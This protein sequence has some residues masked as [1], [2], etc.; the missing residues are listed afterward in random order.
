MGKVTIFAE[1][2]E[3]AMNDT[4]FRLTRARLPLSAAL[5]A[6]ACLVTAMRPALAVD[7]PVAKRANV[8]FI[9][10]DDQRFDTIHALGN[11]DIE[12]THLDKLVERG[13]VF[14]NAYC[15]GAMEAAV[16]T[17]S[18]TMLMTGKSLFRIPNPTSDHYAG[19]TLG[20]AFRAAGYATLHVGK[21]GNSFRA[22]NEAFERVVYCHG[23][24]KQPGEQIDQPR[25][26]ADAAIDF[27]RNRDDTR[28]FFIYLAPQYPHDPR[29]APPEFM[30]KYDPA[31]LPLAKNFMPRHPFDNGELEVR[32]E[33]L[34]PV[35][36]TPDVMR[37]HLADYYACITCLDHH[38][39]RIFAAL[40]ETS[41]ADDTLIVF[42]SDQGLAVGGRHGLMGKQNLYEEFK[43]PLILAGPRIEHGRSDALVYLY[44]LFPTCCDLAG[45]PTPT[46]IDGI[47][48]RPVMEGS[49]PRI[50]E[51]LFG[52][53]KDCQ[54][55]VR[56]E[57]W[58]LI[59]YPQ[60]SRFQLFDLV[61]DPWEIADLAPKPEHAEKLT[62]LKR[63]LAEQQDRFNDELP[64]RPN[65]VETESR[66]QKAKK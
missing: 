1:A 54:R 59:W 65:R 7:A 29:I 40:E 16:C 51:W 18:R 38:L 37:R 30:R 49:K 39:G 64:L 63:R 14:T 25:L 47:T 42:T 57:R 22:G 11:L 23:D 12:T 20:G 19:P 4:N 17:P 26:I 6:V 35:P 13:F 2:A 5:V 60:I 56:D 61:H 31:R 46:G 21:K 66:S 10:A 28:P 52:A 24:P 8:L 58:K 41:Q 43:S 15:Q 45:L 53:Y 9:L 48:L 32:D 55:M 44:D 50:R 34:A 62:E 36:R 33:Q 27:L 3:T